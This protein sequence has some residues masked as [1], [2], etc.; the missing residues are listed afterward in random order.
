[1]NSAR[2][3]DSDGTVLMIHDAVVAALAPTH[4]VSLYLRIWRLG[5][6]KGDRA[7]LGDRTVCA[8][9]IDVYKVLVRKV[10]PRA[11]SESDLEIERE[12]TVL[13]S[14]RVNY[15]GAC[16]VEDYPTELQAW[17]AAYNAIKDEEND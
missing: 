15:D 17:R 2:T 5:D 9:L 14:I 7:F 4:G 12:D 8:L 6:P 1:M 16:I 3:T 10:H 13:W 11:Y